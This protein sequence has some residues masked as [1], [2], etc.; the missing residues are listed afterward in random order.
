MT[1]IKVRGKRSAT[2][3]E[4][5]QAGKKRRRPDADSPSVTSSSERSTPVSTNESLHGEA[6]MGQKRRRRSPSLSR[7]EQLPTEILQ[8]IFDFSTNVALPLVSPHLAAQLRD[9]HIYSTV[10]NRILRRVVGFDEGS[11][12]D[13]GDLSA[14]TR[15]LGCRFIDWSF[16]RKWLESEVSVPPSSNPS[17]YWQRWADLK[18]STD[19]LPPIKVLHGPWT[20]DKKAFLRMFSPGVVDLAALSSIH[21]EIASEGLSQAIAEVSSEAVDILLSMGVAGNTELLRQAVIDCGCNKDIV[22]ALL[23]HTN[24]R[25]HGHAQLDLLDPALW[26][27][28]QRAR[29]DR[30]EKGDWLIHLLRSRAR[31]DSKTAIDPEANPTRQL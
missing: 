10:T 5:W 13:R 9:Q 2:P 6:N 20:D 15:L 30:N 16:L 3:A 22:T 8:T 28:A 25:H 31:D 7:L 23:G 1:A 4:K 21:H 17:V 14:A 29:Q 24:R 27:W 18:P 19:L 11:H 12:A 26:S